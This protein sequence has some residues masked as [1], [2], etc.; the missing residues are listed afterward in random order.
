MFPI[1][2]DLMER[3]DGFA[4][5]GAQRAYLQHLDHRDLGLVE[6]IGREVVPAVA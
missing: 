3:L 5:A 2:D 6:R 1:G 4:A